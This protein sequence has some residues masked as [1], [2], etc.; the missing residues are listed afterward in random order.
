MRKFFIIGVVSLIT[1]TIY[2]LYR[3][4][5]VGLKTVGGSRGETGL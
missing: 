2:I 4:D 3:D 1:L 5:K